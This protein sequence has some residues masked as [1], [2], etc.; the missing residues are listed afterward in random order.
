MPPAPT[1]PS[2]CASP[3]RRGTLKLE[4]KYQR[5]LPLT[6][7]PPH[8]PTDPGSPDESQPPSLLRPNS[9]RDIRQNR[10]NLQTV[11]RANPKI[12]QDRQDRAAPKTRNPARSA[13]ITP[14][15][16]AKIGRIGRNGN[17]TYRPKNS[18]IRQEWQ[19]RRLETTI[20]SPVKSAAPLRATSAPRRSR[21]CSQYR[22]TS[23]YCLRVQRTARTR[24][25]VGGGIPS[26]HAL[27]AGMISRP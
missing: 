27:A 1:P 21:T 17:S 18:K 4:Q 20:S 24:R 23:L 19:R 15:K 8:P 22:P 5:V 9:P 25:K 26:C 6:N 7:S 12:R 2:A 11:S 13:R 14:A 3:L 16:N 10:Q